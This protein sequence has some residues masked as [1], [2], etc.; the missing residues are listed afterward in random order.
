M[1]IVVSLVV[2]SFLV[3]GCATIGKAESKDDKLGRYATE[4]ESMDIKTEFSS[5][6]VAPSKNEKAIST[7]N[8]GTQFLLE[9]KL[10]EAEKYLTE[11]IE[12]DPLFV[13]AMDHLGI[14]YRRQERLSEAEGI[15]LKSIEINNKNKTPYQNLAIVYRMQNRLNDA[16]EQY[17]K[18]IQID[19]DDPESYYGIGELFY[20]VGDYNNS[21]PFIDKAIEL[22]ID[23]NSPY[24]Y[25]AFFYKG[26]MYFRMN[27]YEE[28]L[29]Y[30]EEARKGNP[31]NI[32]LEETI[33]EIKNKKI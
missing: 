2:V 15:Y 20:I 27:N 18:I 25:D 32:M 9:N 29:K 33:D 28:A 14:V 13:D 22:Y 23:L 8:I 12:L 6:M 21:M 26:M 7:Y 5:P 16:F 3:L 11:A 10:T 4:Y 31:N 1:K 17:K 19:P 24:V 30:L